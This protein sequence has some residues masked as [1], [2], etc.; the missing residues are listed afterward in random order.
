MR[1]FGM[2]GPVLAVHEQDV[3]PAVVVVVDEGAAWPHGFG[4]P[5]FPEGAV[6]VG[7]VDAGLGGDVAE[8]DGWAWRWLEQSS[9]SYHGDTEA[10]R[11]L[12]RR[13][14]ISG[15]IPELLEPPARF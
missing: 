3:G 1:R 8:G 7:E 15:A 13:K 14:F 6:V 4:K 5:L 2:A 11:K 10:R 12:W 9:T